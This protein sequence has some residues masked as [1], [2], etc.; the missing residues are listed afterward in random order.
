MKINAPLFSV[1]IFYI[2]LASVYLLLLAFNYD[3]YTSYKKPEI[4]KFTIS[5]EPINLTANN[6]EGVFLYKVNIPS[7]HSGWVIK[8]SEQVIGAP[9]W[10]VHHV[11]LSKYNAVEKLCPHFG[12]RIYSA[13]KEATPVDLP[14]GYG[15]SLK[16]ND[17][18]ILFTHL[19]N[20]TG[21]NYSNVRVEITLEYIPYYHRLKEVKPIWLDAENCS[22]DPSFIVPPKTDNF[23]KQADKK[24]IMEKPG[25]LVYAY[26]HFHDYGRYL[27][28]IKNDQPILKFISQ[29]DKEGKILKIPYFKS[30]SG[31]EYSKG[32]L[33]DI[34]SVYDNPLIEKID[35]MA[36]SLLY[37]YEPKLAW[38]ESLFSSK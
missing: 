22:W 28:L 4:Y 33:F 32:D 27:E 9:N 17:K 19:Y 24:Y 38:L 37:V 34:K 18:F 31:I 15:Y 12:E 1:R 13:A 23:I 26:G 35:G 7:L 16:S 29:N 8:M 25:K 20:P 6:L 36:I 10:A 14:K 2:L 21:Q 30:A 3:F 11:V 5:S